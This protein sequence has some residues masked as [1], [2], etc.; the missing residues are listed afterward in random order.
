MFIQ[1]I[2]GYFRT[3]PS[4]DA[5]PLASTCS[6][7]ISAACHRPEA[8]KEAHL[9]PVQWGVEGKDDEGVDH[10]SF[11]TSQTVTAPSEGSFYLGVSPPATEKRD[12]RMVSLNFRRVPPCVSLPFHRKKT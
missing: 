7:A 3:Y 6:A 12:G 10:C 8:D 4:E 1:I 5:M 9:L 11:T 2:H